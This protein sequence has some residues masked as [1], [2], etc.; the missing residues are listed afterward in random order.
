MDMREPVGAGAAQQGPRSRV[1]APRAGGAD[2]VS[3]VR[4]VYERVDSGDLQGLSALFSDDVVYRRPGYEPMVGRAEL[5]RFYQQERII[6]EGVHTPDAIV[7]NGGEVAVHG[8]FAGRL[9]DG[10]QVELRFADFF[11]TGA[12]GRFSRRDTFFFAPLV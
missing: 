9:K 3:R 11:T 2:P 4:Q 1:P 10:R 8:R 7:E 12:D 5:D 6:D